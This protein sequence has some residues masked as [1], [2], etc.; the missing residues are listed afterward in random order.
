MI[1]IRLG[2]TL[3]VMVS[4]IFFGMEANALTPSGPIVINGQNGTVITGLKIASTRGDCVQIINST[5]VTISNSEIGP[6][7]TNLATAN[8]RGVYIKGGTKNSVYDSYIHVDN[9]ASGCCDSH[10]GVLV[11][12]STYVTIQGNVIA[13]GESNIEINGAPSDHVSVVG[14]FLLNPQ[15][16]GS[17]GQNVQSWPASPSSPN[18]N[19]VV[20]GNYT[21]SSTDTSKYLHPENQEDSMNFGFTNG[22]IAMSNYIVGGHSGSGCGIVGDDGANDASFL[23]NVLTNTGQC[24]IGIA[25]GVG[26]TVFG[27]KIL[28]LT[29]VPGAGNVALYVWNQYG[30]ACGAVALSDNIADELTTRGAHNPYWNAG[31]C[32]AVTEV[33]DNF[34]QSAYNYLYPM[35]ATNPP[36]A[37]PPEPKSCV[38]VSPYTT[39]MSLPSC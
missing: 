18:T 15:N 34:G 8:S 25:N 24:G 35:S 26:Y 2:V 29:P 30:T 6:C 37:I 13:Y 28:N 31:N 5:N 22:I 9:L 7:G 36:P 17:R 11:D 16:A 14:N 1:R 27:N 20:S 21:L 38:A 10:D 32:G 19:I 4:G 3:A 23:N 12:G 33:N 39:N